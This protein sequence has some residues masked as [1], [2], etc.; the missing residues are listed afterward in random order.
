MGCPF[1]GCDFV[2]D[3]KFSGVRNHF[4]KHF[5]EQIEREA[6]P[7]AFLTER[8]KSNCMSKT[9]CSVAVLTA[10]GE[11]VHH[12]GI[13]HCAVDDLYQDF[14]FRWLQENYPHHFFKNRCP[15][16]DYTYHNEKDFLEHLSSVHYFNSILSEVEDMVKFSLT[17]FEE[18]KCMAN[19]YKCPFCKKKF[20]NLADGS[21][22]RDVK[23][24]VLHCG[25]EHG[26]ALYYLMS[27]QKIDEMRKLLCSINI[28]EEPMDADDD[29]MLDSNHQLGFDL[30]NVK[31]EPVEETE[32]EINNFLEVEM[33]DSE[34]A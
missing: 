7:R 5:R 17:Y 32:T 21:N 28:K 1:Q 2:S 15:Y 30:Q 4:L 20:K 10:R 26:F 3:R 14:A 24:M 29:S 27:D 33:H 8:E 9:G 6:K 12:F 31:L 34:E 19:M 25:V 13:F 23:E 18:Y 11:L 16:D 22:V